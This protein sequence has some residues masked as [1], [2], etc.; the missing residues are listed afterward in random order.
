MSIC[1][2][3]QDKKPMPIGTT[4]RAV[5]SARL[6]W[7]TAYEIPLFGGLLNLIWGFE[8]TYN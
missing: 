7:R 8:T 5:H 4:I 6:A 3:D 1:T 2:R